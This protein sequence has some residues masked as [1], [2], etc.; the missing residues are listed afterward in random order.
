M[1]SLG[2][3]TTSYVVS[4]EVGHL[5]EYTTTTGYN[6][7]WNEIQDTSHTSNWTSDYSKTTSYD[8]GGSYA[9]Y[10][11]STAVEPYQVPYD[12]S[13]YAQITTNYSTPLSGLE[14]I[15][16]T[17]RTSSWTST[18]GR[19]TQHGT[20]ITIQ[21][22]VTD[23]NTVSYSAEIIDYCYFAG[24]YVAGYTG[25]NGTVYADQYY[26]PQNYA[27]GSHTTTWDETYTTTTP[28]EYTA[29]EQTY[30]TTAVD[31]PMS[32][33]VTDITYTYNRGTEHLTTVYISDTGYNTI[34]T[35]TVTDP[36]YYYYP[37]MQ[38]R[39]TVYQTN[40]SDWVTSSTY[41]FYTVPAS[42][43]TIESMTEFNSAFNTTRITY[44]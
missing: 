20:W 38:N 25:Y 9:S 28:T 8:A 40:K 11:W 22:S 26:A 6:S 3:Y 42:R 29:Y 23:T 4:D 10:S 30:Y 12:N 37:N 31:V 19:N 34:S 1:A 13:Y 15:T 16:F 7:Y 41:N 5:T 32:A 33:E 39:N 27:C 18:E 44:G 24:G 17:T 21:S 14:Q 36:Y 2:N 43:S 35:A